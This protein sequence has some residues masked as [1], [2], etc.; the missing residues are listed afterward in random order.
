ML[1]NVSEW[2][3]MLEIVVLD[4]LGMFGTDML[5]FNQNYRESAGYK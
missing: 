5:I 3:I 2:G 4:R 1:D